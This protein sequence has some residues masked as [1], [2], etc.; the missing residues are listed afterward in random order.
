MNT[1]TLSEHSQLLVKKT[2]ICDF[3]EEYTER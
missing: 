1:Y 3:I 2:L